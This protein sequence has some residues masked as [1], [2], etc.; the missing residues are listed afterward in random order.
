VDVNLR[1][2]GSRT[3]SL[4]AL[5]RSAVTDEPISRAFVSVSEVEQNFS[6]DGDGRVRLQNIPEGP[7]FIRVEAVGF[8]PADF[9]V[10]IFADEQIQQTFYLQPEPEKFGTCEGTVKNP[11]GTGLTAVFTDMNGSIPSFGTNP[12]TG[13]FNHVLPEGVQKFQ[14]QAENYLPQE[15]ECVVKGGEASRV[16]VTLTRPERATLLADQIILPDAI[17]FGFDSDQIQ[18]QSL[19]VLDQVV[20]V[21][22]EVPDFGRLRIEGHSDS[23]G[24]AEYNLRLS[25]RRAESVRQYLIQQ[26]LEGSQLESIGFGAQRPVATNETEEG[27]AENRRVEFHL[28]RAKR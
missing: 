7:K 27:R 23:T 6:S 4:F 13:E 25:Q 17:F 24:N 8:L 11:D 1:L 12:L 9:S 16:E 14:V 2:I 5:L 22:K 28:E 3:G 10:E 18:S 26:G 20:E 19:N 21:L 15:I